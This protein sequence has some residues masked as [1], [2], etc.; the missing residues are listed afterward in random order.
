LPPLD[1]T[2]VN[3]PDRTIKNGQDN[4]AVTFLKTYLE[5]N[6]AYELVQVEL[7]PK[8]GNDWHYHKDFVEKFHVLQGNLTV[9]LDGKEIVLKENE[10]LEAPA[11]TMHK[12]YNTS[13]KRAVFTV[14]IN[15]GRN[16]EKTL[17]AAYGL[18]NDGHCNEQGPTNPWHLIL[19]LGYSESFLPMLPGFI[20][21]PLIP[22]LAKIAQWKGEHKALEVY[23]R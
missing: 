3:R 19:I 18:C 8:G 20:Q 12:F 21:E 4:Y 5:T 9:G 16:F 14:E 10:R 6:G 2:P 11:K 23:Y 17:R 1:D 22:A 7:A 15:P 13:G